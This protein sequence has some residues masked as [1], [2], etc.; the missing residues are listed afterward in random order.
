MINVEMGNP[1]LMDRDLSCLSVDGAFKNYEW[2]VDL[3]RG[4][5]LGA[6]WIEILNFNKT[7][8]AHPCEHSFLFLH[9]H[10]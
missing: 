8:N 7:A 10:R 5:L 3:T 2:Q 1:T 6:P 9:K 4:T